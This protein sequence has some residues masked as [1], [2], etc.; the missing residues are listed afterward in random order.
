M[1]APEGVTGDAYI[2]QVLE[3]SINSYLPYAVLQVGSDSSQKMQ[4][5]QKRCRA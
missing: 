4:K 2:D 5:M 3:R 1:P